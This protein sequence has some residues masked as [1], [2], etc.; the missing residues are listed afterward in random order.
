MSLKQMRLALSISGVPLEGNKLV[1]IVYMDESGTGKEDT[2]LV[3]CGAIVHGDTLFGPVE[4]YLQSLID[5]HIPAD[6]KEGFYFH[7]SEIYSGSR[8]GKSASIFADRQE[9]PAERRWAILDDMV[10]IPKDFNIPI[11]VA[12]IEKSEFLTKIKNA[13][14]EKKLDV[15]GSKAVHACG[16]AVCEL[17]VEKW[18]RENTTDEFAMITME[19]ND[20][21]RQLAKSTHL[22]LKN[23][24]D[25]SDYGEISAKILPFVKIRDGLQ[26]ANK[27]E[28]RFLQIADVCAWACRRALN[29]AENADRFIT[30]LLP[31][32]FEGK[33][34]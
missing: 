34:A 25:L 21:V 18:M 7:A 10:A 11:C 26:F 24:E 27:S 12:W 32:I 16:I 19:N 29:H 31:Q 14:P 30:P 6:K 23:I 17:I 4:D 28:S 3:V 15:E 20:E 2:H 33:E 22:Y 9:W 8:K 13:P 5:K 1:R